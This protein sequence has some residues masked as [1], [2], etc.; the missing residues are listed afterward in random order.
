MFFFF[1]MK[2]ALSAINFKLQESIQ[3]DSLLIVF[4]RAN[5]HWQLPFL[6]ISNFHL[7]NMQRMEATVGKKPLQR[8]LNLILPYNSTLA[9]EFDG[10]FTPL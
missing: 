9:R 5:H 1:E 7:S 4:W 2:P 8:A 6:F 3:K 10:S